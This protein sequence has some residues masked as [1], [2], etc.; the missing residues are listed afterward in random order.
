MG[1]HLVEDG[2]TLPAGE[3]SFNESGTYA[4]TFQVGPYTD[5]HGELHLILCDGYAASA[6]AIQA[7][8]LDPILRVHT[9]M[10]LFSS[11]FQVSHE[12]ERLVM[13]LDPEA[14]DFELRLTGVLGRELAPSEVGEYREILRNALAAGMPLEQRTVTVSD[15]F[16]N[17]QWKVLA[18]AGYMLDDPY[19]G[20]P[21]V[22]EVGP[23]TFRVTARATTERGSLEARLTL[24][25]R[26]TMEQS[27]LVFSPLLDRFYGGLDYRS[28]AVKISDSGRIRHE[29][30]TLASEALE[31][32]DG[33]V[34]RVHFELIDDA[35]LASDKKEL[36][37]QVLQWYKA[38]HPIWF[39][40]L[41][42]A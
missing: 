6:E 9:S 29:L 26:E 3:K 42:I 41:E 16:P 23:G 13:R 22:E 33:D 30:Q 38:H 8:S 12:R 1:A 7:A 21:G 36:I 34:I 10:C 39:R 35:V 32:L 28:R 5:A 20:S 37:R 27:R 4:A 2:W 17:K 15:F 24:R 11:L 25:L 40:W 18:L 19:S 31:Y 14:S